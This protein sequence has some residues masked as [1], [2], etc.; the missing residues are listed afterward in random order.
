MT[1]GAQVRWLRRRFIDFPSSTGR[2]RNRRTVCCVTR[3]N[4][5]TEVRFGRGGSEV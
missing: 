5:C 3:R 1:H 4:M 2:A